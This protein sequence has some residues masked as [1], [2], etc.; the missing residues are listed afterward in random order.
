MNCAHCGTEVD[1]SDMPW[2]K[3]SPPDANPQVRVY[4]STACSD[5]SVAGWMRAP[6]AKP[7]EAAS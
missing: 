4:C 7:P 3:P 5:A 1:T 6:D 2:L